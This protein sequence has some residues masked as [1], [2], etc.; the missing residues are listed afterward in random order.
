METL[1][2]TTAAALYTSPSAPAGSWCPN[3]NCC[4][5][6]C[7]PVY[8]SAAAH[9]PVNIRLSLA[10]NKIGDG[11]AIHIAYQKGR[12]VAQAYLQWSASG[13]SGLRVELEVQRPRSAVFEKLVT[14]RGPDNGFLFETTMP[15][16]YLFRATATDASGSRNFNT[17]S[18]TFPFIEES[19]VNPQ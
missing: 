3:L 5:Q 7:E 8:L 16:T 12:Y 18:V 14:N 10:M 19:E 15:G 11:K 1:N 17:L 9:R 13:G 2:Q 6:Y 4:C